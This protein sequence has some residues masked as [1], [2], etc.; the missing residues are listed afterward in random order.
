M[1]VP[2]NLRIPLLVFVLTA[3]ILAFMVGFS[4]AQKLKDIKDDEDVT[5]SIKDVGT[6]DLT[7]AEPFSNSI[8]EV[9]GKGG[10]VRRLPLP[11]RS[12]FTGRVKG[13]PDS[14]VV[15]SVDDRGARGFALK[16]NGKTFAIGTD[17]KS[18]RN[19]AR[20]SSSLPPVFTDEPLIA[21]TQ[22]GQ[23]RSQAAQPLAAGQYRRIELAIETDNEL[24]NRFSG[25]SNAVLDYLGR[26]VAAAN[27]IYQRDLDATIDVVYIRLWETPDPWTGSDTRT[28][29]EQVQ[30]YWRSNER[31]RHR[32]LVHQVSGKSGVGGRAWFPGV[33]SELYGYGVSGVHGT[34]DVS[35]DVWDVHVFCHEIGHNCGS[36]HTHCYS[37]PIDMCYGSEPGC[38]QGPTED[39]F[40]GEMMSYC[41][42]AVH[43]LIFRERVSTQIKNTLASAGCLD[44][45]NGGPSPSPTLSPGPTATPKPTKTPKRD[46]FTCPLTGQVGGACN[47]PSGTKW[48]KPNRCPHKDSKIFNSKCECIPR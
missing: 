25:N 4:S 40:D 37:P 23:F 16:E 22:S 33:C 20:S 14:L 43:N 7:R 17:L 41:R 32:D 18:V 19:S 39:R 1:R 15:V 42:R 27:A 10:K 5:V 47:C 34:T 8:V 24:L 36:H 31:N 28:M 48:N 21:P 46:K 9:V 11:D 45:T 26:L 13:E 2:L 38:Y 44:L 12:F 29:L 3:V 35:R 6:V 30:N